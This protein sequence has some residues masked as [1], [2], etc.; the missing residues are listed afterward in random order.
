[1]IK[2]DTS[3]LSSSLAAAGSAAAAA[4]RAGFDGVWSAELDHDPF[5][6]LVPAALS[7]SRV[8][9]G[10]AIA[11]AFSRTP[12]TIANIA[13][14]LH[15]ASNGRMIVGLGSQIKPHIEKRFSMP[16]SQPAARMR[17]FISAMNAIFAAW[18]NGTKL[19]FRGDFYTHTL[20]TPTFDPGPLPFA[21]PKIVLAAVGVAMTRVAAE[22]SD[23]ILL[24]GFTTERYV[25]EV[26]MP[27][28]EEALG[29]AGRNRDSFSVKYAPFVVTGRD[30]DE[31]AASATIAKERIAFYASTPAYRGVLE[32]HGWGELQT[33]LN[34]LS[35]QGEWTKMG[36]LIDEE[37]L[38]AF[39][40]VAPID[41]LGAAIAKRIK[42][43][44]DRT[45]LHLP[46][47][48][49]AETTATIIQALRAAG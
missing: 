7:T 33:E 19:D 25:R 24:H 38:D 3:L 6:P 16:W 37:I 36:T 48:I 5:L 8:E 17:E 21:A 15:A 2:V 46:K 10:T 13:W 43:L 47:E 23:G 35:K 22:V 26:T 32:V 18:Q 20:M 1:M 29:A 27:V 49:D 45:S 34:Q 44:A 30:E 14:D 41:Q 9:I 39:A 4:E 31:M 40:V 42:G 11:V 28:V 12:M